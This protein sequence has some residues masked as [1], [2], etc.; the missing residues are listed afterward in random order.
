MLRWLVYASVSRPAWVLLSAAALAIGGAA[1][2]SRARYD[3]FPE[4]V[5]AQAEIQTEAQGMVAEQIEQ[6]VTQPLEN[7]LNGAPQIA[8]VRSESTPGLSA[9]TV[10]FTA[11]ADPFRARQLLAERIAEAAA[12]LPAGVKA[13]TL[14]AM[15]SSTMDLLKIGFMSEQLSPTALRALVEQTVRP[16]LL[17][18]PGVA[19]ATVFGGVVHELDV[20][21]RPERLRALNVSLDD[22]L[23]AVRAAGGVRGAGFVD[24]PNQRVVLETEG[25]AN[26][27]ERLARTV[28]SNTNG[29]ATLLGDIA[30]VEHAAAPAFGDALIMGKPGVLLVLLSQH[31]ANTLDVTHRV[32]AALA[33]LGPVLASAGVRVTPA[34]HRPATFIETALTHMRDALLLGGGLVAAV[35][36]VFL[37]SWRTA[38]ISFVTIPLSL[39]TAVLAMSAM[40]WTLN[41]LTLG[42]LAVALGVVVDDAIIDVEN[43]VRRLRA[44]PPGTDRRAVILDASMEVRRPVLLATAVAGLVF[45]PVAALPGLQGSFFAPLAVAF[46]IA[47]FASLVLALT[48]VPALCF[49]LLR[50]SFLEREPWWLRRL[51]LAHRRVLHRM[52]HRSALL[53]IVALAVGV[54]AVGLLLRL[55]TELLPAFRERHFVVQLRG[56]P[57]TSLSATLRLGVQVSER[58]LA[59]P[60]I[61]TVSLQAGRATAS[62]DAWGPERA[63]AHVELSPDTSGADEV[64]IEAALHA[65]LADFPGVQTEVLTFLG[66]RVGESL[67][68]EAAPFVLNLFGTDLTLLDEW[69]QRIAGALRPLAGAGDVRA[70]DS[71][72][73]PSVRARLDPAQLAAH[74]LRALDVLDAV[75]TAI[76]GAVVNQIYADGRTIDVRVS[77]GEGNRTAPESVGDVLLRAADGRLV[78]LRGVADVS[79]SESRAVISHEGARRRQKVTASPAPHDAARFVADARAALAALGPLPAGMYVEIAG[80]AREAAAARGDLA[81]YSVLAAIVIVVLLL[82]SFRER[83][84]ALIVLINVP[85]ALVGGVLALA[86]CGEALSMGAL[87]GFIALFGISAR[88]GIMLLSHYE[89]LM[90]NEGLRWSRHTA[91]RGVRERLTPIFMT[92]L[93]TALGVV[94]LALGSGEAGREIEGPM[95]I[96]LLG[97]LLSSTVLNLLVLPLIAARALRTPPLLGAT[98]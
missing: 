18:V 28:V 44:A 54:L 29:R 3:V 13:P 19:R 25:Q 52:Q 4:F 98:S 45:L 35:L 77:V 5:P 63:E 17:G 38:L 53:W 78:M 33:E 11:G 95:A 39:L 9:V 36:L 21:L 61:S 22:A 1:G 2:V 46:L 85:F 60:G 93:V 71:A 47:V 57:G 48:L 42:G 50:T 62:E 84:S 23:A 81:R 89:H 27:V 20:R 68:G 30:D 82:L 76:G 92:A 65:L 73:L 43:I 64:R 66:D 12:S 26:T 14:S 86:V 80:T 79:L 58:M 96:V 10:V 6:L 34:L 55:N 69:A 75:A 97:G 51:K 32:E 40:G 16:R 94:P 70:S 49:V 59:V 56:T 88:N 91:L 87:V 8:A 72:L 41:T 74:G 24:T 15:T 90:L 83:R 7:V 67:S 31:G 37:R